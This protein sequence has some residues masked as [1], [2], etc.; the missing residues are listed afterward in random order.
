MD[1]SPSLEEKIVEKGMPKARGGE[2]GRGSE[3]KRRE[4]I[5][6]PI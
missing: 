6:G 1:D 5:C 4:K 3:K 2:E